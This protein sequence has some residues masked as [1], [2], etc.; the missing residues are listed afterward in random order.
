MNRSHYDRVV[1]IQSQ[2]SRANSFLRKR[3]VL[4]MGINWS[5]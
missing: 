5:R 4:R 2:G 3:I 1:R